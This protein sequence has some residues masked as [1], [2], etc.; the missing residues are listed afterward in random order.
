MTQEKFEEHTF[1]KPWIADGI[2]QSYKEWGSLATMEKLTRATG[3]IPSLFVCYLWYIRYRIMELS[4]IMRCK[5][6]AGY[7][8]L[9]QTI[10]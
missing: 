5:G 10:L 7:Q 6:Y 1:S 9:F 2:K 4:M 8:S 3:L